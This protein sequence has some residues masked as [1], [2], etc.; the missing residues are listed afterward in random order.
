MV[1]KGTLFNSYWNQGSNQGP[2]YPG[3]TSTGGEPGGNG[4]SITGRKCACEE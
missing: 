1:N 3:G 2:G 4:T